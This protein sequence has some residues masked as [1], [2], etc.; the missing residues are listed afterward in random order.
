MLY[1]YQSKGYIITPRMKLPPPTCFVGTVVARTYLDIERYPE[2]GRYVSIEVMRRRDLMRDVTEYH[3]RITEFGHGSL[4]G[5]V[6]PLP[7]KTE[8]ALR[9]LLK[10]KGI[11]PPDRVVI[12]EL[13]AGW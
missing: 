7:T 6:I 4:V 12:Q 1:S 13:V 9:N 8:E 11:T 2:G 5:S 10:E 3:V